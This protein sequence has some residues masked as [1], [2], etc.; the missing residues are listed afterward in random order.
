M[1][2]GNGLLTAAAC[3]ALIGCG[4]GGG[5]GGGTSAAP[6]PSPTPDPSP[7][8]APVPS[9]PGVGTAA[10][11]GAING[12]TLRLQKACTSA[13]IVYS[14]GMVSGLQAIVPATVSADTANYSTAGP[15]SLTYQGEQHFQVR[16]NPEFAFYESPSAF[17]LA[18]VNT[19]TFAAPAVTFGYGTRG[20][21]CFFAAGLAATVPV[22]QLVYDGTVDGLAQSGSG[23]RR[24]I[25][26]SADATMNFAAG[27]GTLS[28]LLKGYPDAFGPLAGQAQGTIGSLT[29]NLT[30]TG[31]TVTA[32]NVTGPAGY[33]GTMQGELVGAT[34]MALA[35]QLRNA[36][37]EVI[38]GAVA[39]DGAAGRGAWD[40]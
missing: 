3:V 6:S 19:T 30:L 9:P 14:G 11:A 29:A 26:S 28:I 33:S 24:L 37:G 40:Y 15:T 7:T 2:I 13:P 32:A 27:S 21:L 8:P 31:T 35:F 20:G 38:F 18:I 39:L 23:T 17:A 1:R 25:K 36:T 22:G 12:S 10:L 5:S 4:G 16:G 34:G